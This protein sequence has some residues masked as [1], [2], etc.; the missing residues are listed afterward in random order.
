MKKAPFPI[1][2]IISIAS[3]IIFMVGFYLN[4][5]LNLNYTWKG[6]WGKILVYTLIFYWSS[7][8]SGIECNKISEVL[9]MMDKI[10]DQH[11]DLYNYLR[12]YLIKYKDSE[13]PKMDVF[14]NTLLIRL[15]HINTNKPMS[16]ATIE[17]CKNFSE[18]DRDTMINLNL[19]IDHWIEEFIIEENDKLKK[20]NYRI[21]SKEITEIAPEVQFNTISFLLTN[22]C[23]ENIKKD[24]VENL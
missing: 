22:V 20:Q 11:H 14:K 1:W 6:D 18:N 24:V 23:H 13:K 17:L 8:K 2:T 21:S 19:L 9:K 10:D 7:L 16:I 12:K 5:K 15:V 4:G 3:I